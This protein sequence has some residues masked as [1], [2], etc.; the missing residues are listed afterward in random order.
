M[1]GQA[2]NEEAENGLPPPEAFLRRSCASARAA[3][4]GEGSIMLMCVRRR[5]IG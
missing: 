3:A 4:P 5:D 2:G 1:M